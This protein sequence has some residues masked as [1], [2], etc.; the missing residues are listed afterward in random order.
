MWPWFRRKFVHAATTFLTQYSH[1]NVFFFLSFFI[2]DTKQSSR[3]IISRRPRSRS[4][5]MLAHLVSHSRS[6]SMEQSQ[7]RI[8]R[9][10]HDS[11]CRAEQACSL[12]LFSS[13]SS[14]LGDRSI[15][16]VRFQETLKLLF[17]TF[18]NTDRM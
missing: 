8:T 11:S 2:I 15:P 4:L 1:K 14:S 5:T 18:R 17:P 3:K 7:L 6:C 13:S 12:R 16:Q 9:V 10:R